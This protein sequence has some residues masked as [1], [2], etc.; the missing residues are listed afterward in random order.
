[1]YDGLLYLFLRTAA[2]I[3]E[4]CGRKNPKY[5]G[6]QNSENHSQTAAADRAA[7]LRKSLVLQKAEKFKNQY[8][9]P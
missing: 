7:K 4:N 9:L 5:H 6:T 3:S 1:V 8:A 2:Y